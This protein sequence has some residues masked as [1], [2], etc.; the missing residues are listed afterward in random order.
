[1]CNNK[2]EQIKAKFRE[3]DHFCHGCTVIRNNFGNKHTLNSQD[4][5]CWYWLICN[6][7]HMGTCKSIPNKYRNNQDCTGRLEQNWIILNQSSSIRSNQYQIYTITTIWTEGALVLKQFLTLSAIP[8]V[9][10]CN[11]LVSEWLSGMPIFREASTSA[12][13][14]FVCTYVG[15]SLLAWNI[16]STPIVKVMQWSN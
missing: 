5:L 10:L 15:F 7:Y 3:K 1:M 13:R 14:M 12:N 9:W 6:L 16:V 4:F 8:R 11:A 2:Q